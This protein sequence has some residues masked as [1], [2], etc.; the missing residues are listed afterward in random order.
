MKIV[1]RDPDLERI[2]EFAMHEELGNIDPSIKCGTLIDR[3]VRKG[4]TNF[5]NHGKI[6]VSFSKKDYDAEE[7]IKFG[8]VIEIVDEK[9]FY[10]TISINDIRRLLIHGNDHIKK[11]IQN[12]LI[13]T[14]PRNYF[15]DLVD[16]GVIK[17]YDKRINNY[18][19]TYRDTRNDILF[20]SNI[21]TIDK[22]IYDKH[23]EDELS[24]GALDKLTP[25]TIR[26]R[27]PLRKF[28]CLHNVKNITIHPE[29]KPIDTVETLSNLTICGWNSATISNKKYDNVV[30][31]CTMSL[32]EWSEIFNSV[33]MVEDSYSKNLVF[34]QA[35]KIMIHHVNIIK[36]MGVD[37]RKIDDAIWRAD[38]G[39]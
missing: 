14:L 3:L 27:L 4:N 16:A 31:T 19:Y 10:T 6:I 36:C 39:R 26:L 30:V 5:L 29:C 34:C 37:S 17:N 22:F 33:A 7:F 9:N 28:A 32:Y 15:M 24:F 23:N 13:P 2:I 1:F 21:N 8:I 18:I 20:V 38:N 35:Y 25:L 12:V 11:D